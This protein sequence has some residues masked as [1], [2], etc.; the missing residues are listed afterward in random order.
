[1]INLVAIT[2]RIDALL[3]E[4]TEASITYAALEARLALEKVC[5]DRLRQAHN[6]I[7]HDQLKRWQPREVMLTLIEQV[8]KNAALTMKLSISTTPASDSI[9]PEDHEYVEVGTQI[10]FDPKK[11]GQMWQAL[12]GLALHVRLPKNVEDAIPAYGD[13]TRIRAKVEQVR[14]ELLRLSKGTM[15]TSGYGEEVSFDCECGE[16]NRRRAELLKEGDSVFCIDPNCLES[17]IVRHEGD[18]INFYREPAEFECEGCGEPVS[19]PKRRAYKIPLDGETII[20]CGRCGHQN[21]VRWLLAHVKI[22]TPESI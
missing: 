17:Y 3:A 1:M 18:E 21:R 14:D 7:S 11:L 19:F 15:V 13:V 8:D 20:P 22:K 2:E 16:T 9:R 6:Y 4:D 10:G 12:S 5:Y